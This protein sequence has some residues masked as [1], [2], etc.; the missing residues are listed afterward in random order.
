VRSIQSIRPIT[1]SV[2]T[3]IGSVERTILH[4][5]KLH[6]GKRKMMIL[7]LASALVTQ[8]TFEDRKMIQLDNGL[9]VVKTL[10]M[11]A[12]L[13]QKWITRVLNGQMRKPR[14]TSMTN[15]E[16]L[17]LTSLFIKRWRSMES[18]MDSLEL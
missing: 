14:S 2:A 9:A 6:N 16:D 4:G 13:A 3:L 1:E 5:L 7:K 18:T 10:L 17:I 8:D 12:L 11:D 15:H